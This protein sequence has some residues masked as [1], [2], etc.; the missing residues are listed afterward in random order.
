MEVWE[1][2]ESLAGLL[3][4]WK[5]AIIMSWCSK[6]DYSDERAQALTDQIIAAYEDSRAESERIFDILTTEAM[7]HMSDEQYQVVEQALKERREAS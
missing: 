1:Q 3:S 7:L 2:G 5:G 4:P 6:K